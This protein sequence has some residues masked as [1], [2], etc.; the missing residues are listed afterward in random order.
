MKVCDSIHLSPT[1][2]IEQKY[3]PI[4]ERLDLKIDTE[5]LVNLLYTYLI[6]NLEKRE[7][8]LD[9]YIDNFQESAYYYSVKGSTSRDLGK[10]EQAI[11]FYKKV[12]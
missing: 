9:N 11:H 5:P 4:I 7:I 6:P 1:E 3:R 10:F 12:L 8:A 2:V